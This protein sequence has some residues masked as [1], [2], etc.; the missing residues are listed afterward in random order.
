[1]DAE[2]FSDQIVRLLAGGRPRSAEVFLGADRLGD[3][4]SR[5]ARVLLGMTGGEDPAELEA[6]AVESE[7]NLFSGSRLRAREH[8]SIDLTAGCSLGFAD[9]L[10]SACQKAQGPDPTAAERRE[11]L[12]ELVTTLSSTLVDYCSDQC[13]TVVASP[14]GPVSGPPKLDPSTL[15]DLRI[16]L[17][18]RNSGPLT[19]FCRLLGKS[20]PAPT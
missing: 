3:V 11:A 6:P 16:D 4:L 17:S 20:E 5:A 14:A 1:L 12:D 2:T 19:L 18:W 8:G 13:H 15:L 9:E 10:T 7:L